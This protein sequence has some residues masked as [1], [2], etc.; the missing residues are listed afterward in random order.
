[1]KITLYSTLW[2]YKLDY[3]SMQEAVKPSMF[4]I[5]QNELLRMSIRSLTRK[6]KFVENPTKTKKC[7]CLP[8]PEVGPFV[9]EILFT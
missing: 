8:N 3:H 7:Y 9:E 1:M 4:F 5:H 2:L 6:I